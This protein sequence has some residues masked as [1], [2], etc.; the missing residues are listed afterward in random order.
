MTGLLPAYRRRPSPLHAAR[1]GAA[2]AFCAV[3]CLV[4]LTFGT[5]VILAAAL[6]GVLATGVATGVGRELRRAAWIGVPLAL[7]VILVNA[8]V[9]RSGDTLLVRGGEVLGWRLDITLEAVVYGGVAALRVLV[10]VMALALFTAVVDPDDVLRLF[11]R[12]SFRSALTAALAMRLV[13]VLARDAARMSDAARCRPVPPP[14][15]GAARAAL[16]GALDRAVDVAAAL[17]LRGYAGAR[18]PQP[19]SAPWSRHDARVAAATGATALVAVTAVVAGV[20][21]FEA[22]PRLDLELGAAEAALAGALVLLP[23]VPFAGPSAR[24]GVAGG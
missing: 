14:R 23:L 20:G 3:P 1:A 13:P 18:R 9:S 8:L 17:E 2:T 21:G 7:L 19:A 24:L 5:P 10:L 12:V 16:R 11:R 22:Y 4:A 15:A 6:G